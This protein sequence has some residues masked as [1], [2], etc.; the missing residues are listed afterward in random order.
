MFY[1]WGSGKF[2]PIRP[3]CLKMNLIVIAEKN[4]QKLSL[5]LRYYYF[6]Q[7]KLVELNYREH[8]ANWFA[9]AL[10]EYYSG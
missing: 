7:T 6:L 3:S 1:H 2:I 4:V 9:T 8:N 10:C 5:Q